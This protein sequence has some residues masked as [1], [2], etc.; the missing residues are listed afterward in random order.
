MCV[1][2]GHLLYQKSPE[3]GGGHEASNVVLGVRRLEADRM[4]IVYV[5]RHVLL[6]AGR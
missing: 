4:C 5:E 6:G 1:Y 2:Q 3:W